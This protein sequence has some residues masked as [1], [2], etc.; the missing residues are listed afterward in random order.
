MFR[1]LFVMLGEVYGIFRHMIGSSLSLEIEGVDKS[2]QLVP[3]LKPHMS[4]I[5]DKEFFL[6]IVPLFVCA[7]LK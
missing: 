1:V 5:V 3:G 4:T 7:V 2:Q 6:L